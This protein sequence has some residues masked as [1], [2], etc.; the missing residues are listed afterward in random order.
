MGFIVR[1]MGMVLVLGTAVSHAGSGPLRVAVV[2]DGASPIYSQLLDAM[3]QT[4]VTQTKTGSTA[5]TFNRILSQQLQLAN[6]DLVVAV[7]TRSSLK[8][9]EKNLDLP[10][11]SVLIPRISFEKIAAGRD[12]I[13]AIYLDQPLRR[14]VR[15]IRL[16]MPAA[17]DL[18]VLLG[19]STVA[20]AGEV[21][22]AARNQ[23]F[24]PHVVKVKHKDN[25]ITLLE[26]VLEDSEVLLA[27][28][29]P[30][31]FNRNNV[32]SILLTTYRYR[33]PMIGVSPAYI[34]AGALAA[35][36]STPAQIG[37][38][39]AELLARLSPESVHLPNPEYPRY[40]S[41]MTNRPVGRSLGIALDDDGVLF[42][43][44]QTGETS[45]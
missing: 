17:N 30:V 41:V 14:R 32:Q 37:R 26:Q 22:A 43:T 5:I 45:P 34:K 36:Y 3:Q 11:I 6:V 23:R 15:L 10:I 38:Q 29:D 9:I 16:L 27:V 31:V 25:P 2:A 4:V 40:Y 13:S 8:V 21:V 24:N 7:G 44:L 12:R 39:V 33:V 35:V 20:M 18:G 42:K 19:P 28:I 1:V